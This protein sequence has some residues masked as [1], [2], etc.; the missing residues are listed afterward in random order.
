MH[1]RKQTAL[2]QGLP[3]HLCL[4]LHRAS[5]GRTAAAAKPDLGRAPTKALPDR[6]GRAPEWLPGRGGAVGA[7]DDREGRR[8]AG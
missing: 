5:R 3:L 6:S 7:V 1:M 2:A 8:T 4:W